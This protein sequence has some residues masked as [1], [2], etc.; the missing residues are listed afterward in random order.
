MFSTK[1]GKIDKSG[2][3]ASSELGFST[4]MKNSSLKKKEKLVAWILAT[5][6]HTKLA[7]ELEEDKE[8]RLNPIM[9]DLIINGYVDENH[10]KYVKRRRRK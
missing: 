5:E 3:V 10:M 7:E 8:I 4:N 2:Q 1:P 9:K 6:F